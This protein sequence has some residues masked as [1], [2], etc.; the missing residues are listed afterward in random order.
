MINMAYEIIKFLVFPGALFVI[1][2]AFSMAWLVRKVTAQI[3]NRV[4]PPIHQPFFDFA[5]LLAK[6]RMYPI[7]AERWIMHYLPMVQTGIALLMTFFIP[8]WGDSGLISFNGDLYFFLFLL[9][10]HGVTAFFVGWGSRNPYAISGAGRA[11]MTEVSLEIPMSIS[12]AGMAIMTGSMKIAD[13]TAN[14]GTSIFSNGFTP[15]I[16]W[17]FLIPWAMLAFTMLYASIGA[18]EFSPFSAGHAETEIVAGWTTELT[19]GDLA[20]T[21][22]ADYLNLFNLAA[23]SVAL[24]FGGPMVFEFGFEFGHVLTAIIA[25]LTFIIKVILAIFIISFVKTLSSRLRIDQITRA[26][27]NYYLPMS[28]IGVFFVIV[29]H[30]LGG[31]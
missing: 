19:G 20:F 7:G 28:L 26:L 14:I 24:F 17:L 8:I 15:S 5:K 9:G 1:Y 18:L 13:I 2:M 22:F 3:E 29:I 30:Y 16:T 12:L 4:G 6:Q 25:T 11:V 27:W 23:I 10:L 31:L 21:K